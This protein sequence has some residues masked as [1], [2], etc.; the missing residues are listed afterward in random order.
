MKTRYLVVLATWMLTA[1]FLISC[2][3]SPGVVPPV[4]GKQP[5]A[6]DPVDKTEGEEEPEDDVVEVS[7]DGKIVTKHSDLDGDGE[8]EKIVLVTGKSTGYGYDDYTGYTIEVGD[9]VY[10][11]SAY[12]EMIEPRFNVVNI[13]R[14]D[15]FK[16]IAVS[17]YG[18]SSDFFTTFYHYEDDLLTKIGVV[19]GFYGEASEMCEVFGT[20]TIGGSGAIKGVSR[21]NLLHTWFHDSEYRMNPDFT[22]TEVLKD[23]YTMDAEVMAISELTVVKSPA[24]PQEAFTISPG[25]TITIKD[26]DDREWC[27]VVNSKGETG[28]FAVD[29]FDIIRDTGLHANEVFEGLSYAD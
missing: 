17:E 11:L 25:E 21:G 4:T 6:E 22:L 14:S 19:S 28:W 12:T 18:P 3:Q 13:I 24:D 20:V 29:G 9:R 27:S 8:K 15:G 10:E 23:F 5:G 7:A 26:T 2:A 1:V 16:E